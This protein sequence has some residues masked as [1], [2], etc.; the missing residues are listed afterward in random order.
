MED[1]ERKNEASSASFAIANRTR[2]QFS[3][4]ALESI[5]NTW[6]RCFCLLLL[7]FTRLPRVFGMVWIVTLI[8][9]LNV[10]L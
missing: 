5:Y 3:D 2:S 1:E 10:Y 8:Y 7:P 4:N 9:L 6:F